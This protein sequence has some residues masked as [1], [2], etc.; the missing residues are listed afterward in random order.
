MK[1]IKKIASFETADGV[2]HKTKIEAL[3]HQFR[4]DIRG[5]IQSINGHSDTLTT[6]QVANILAKNSGTFSKIVKSYN[7]SMAGNTP[8]TKRNSVEI[9]NFP[10]KSEA[11]VT[12]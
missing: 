9:G 3:A 6:T 5:F 7:L 11:A 10:T 2:I 12:Q 8:K 1:N 4:L